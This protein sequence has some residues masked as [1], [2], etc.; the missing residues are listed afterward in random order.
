MAAVPP[1]VRQAE[2]LDPALL[3]EGG[4]GPSMGAAGARG[5]SRGYQ[6]GASLITA[7]FARS[8][9]DDTSR[10]VMITEVS[11]RVPVLVRR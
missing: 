9:D 4:L 6:G 11:L 5:G 7:R 8:S 2:E 1:L 10:V 3:Q